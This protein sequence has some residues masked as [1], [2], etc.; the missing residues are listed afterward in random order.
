MCDHGMRKRVDAH[1]SLCCFLSSRSSS[2]LC[3]LFCILPAHLNPPPQRK[4]AK[5]FL[6]KSVI[7]LPQNGKFNHTNDR[8]N[9]CG[10]RFFISNMMSLGMRCSTAAV[11]HYQEAGSPVTAED[12]QNCS[13]STN[14]SRLRSL[15]CQQQPRDLTDSGSLMYHVQPSAERKW[16]QTLAVWVGTKRS[17]P[18]TSISVCLT[19]RAAESCKQKGL[20]SSG[21]CHLNISSA[22]CQKPFALGFLFFE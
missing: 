21:P 9:E 6:D 16:E 4:K 1:P 11:A 2:F 13:P 8:T 14:P 5:L 17:S 10:G 7:C 22:S 18:N 3:N 15:S 12:T 19:H 20:H